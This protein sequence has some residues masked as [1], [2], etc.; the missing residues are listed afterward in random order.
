MITPGEACRTD[1][2]LAR[3]KVDKVEIWLANDTDTGTFNIAQ[4]A[5]RVSAGRINTPI[6]GEIIRVLAAIAD[7]DTLTRAHAAVVDFADLVLTFIL[8]EVVFKAGQAGSALAQ[9]I[10]QS[11]PTLAFITDWRSFRLAHLTVVDV[12]SAIDTFVH[13]TIEPEASVA[14]IAHCWV[15]AS[16]APSDVA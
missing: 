10:D 12:A 14:D 1:L 6:I 4:A 11:V 2:A 13:N 16:L 15:L 5:A 8:L 7:F 3:A 9:T